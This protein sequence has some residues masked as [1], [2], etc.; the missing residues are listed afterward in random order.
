MGWGGSRDS[1]GWGLRTGDG[2]RDGH[3][4][5][6]DDEAD[7]AAEAVGRGGS[8]GAGARARGAGDAARPGGGARLA[9]RAAARDVVAAHDRDALAGAV[10]AVERSG[11]PGAVG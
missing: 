8:A 4:V 1:S 11:R 7:L 10:R 5:R 2:G 9:G 3:G 6:R